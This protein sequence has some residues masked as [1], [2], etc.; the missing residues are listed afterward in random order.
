MNKILQ[1]G[2]ALFSTLI[3]SASGASA[4]ERWIVT[5]SEREAWMA[6]SAL[7][8]VRRV[9]DYEVGVYEAQNGW[10]AVAIGPFTEEKVSIAFYDLMVREV[11]PED[12]RVSGTGCCIQ[13]VERPLGFPDPEDIENTTEPLTLL[14]DLLPQT[15]SWSIL[16]TS[17]EEL[18]EEMS[19]RADEIGT[20]PHSHLFG[21]SI[22]ELHANEHKCM[23]LSKLLQ[24]DLPRGTFEQ[25]YPDP[26]KSIDGE[27]LRLAAHSLGNFHYIV[28]STLP[29]GEDRWKHDWNLGCAD[30][31]DVPSLNYQTPTISAFYDVDESTLRI[32]GDVESGFAQRVIS[33]L[34]MH[35]EVD[36]VALGSGGGYIYEAF[37]AGEAI[38][39]RGLTTTLYNDCMSACTLVF[40]AGTDRLVWS[41]YPRLGFHMAS[42]DGVEL[43]PGDGVYEDIRAYSDWMGISGLRIV[44]LMMK[45]GSSDM[46]FPELEELGRLGV[47][48]WCQR[49][50]C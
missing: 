49:M 40:L 39:S 47:V 31:D 13:T 14:W 11:I 12:S 37:E 8:I 5:N 16:M 2:M 50:A 35:P 44:G 28:Q 26:L 45:A 43:H 27:G 20:P 7:D 36:T 1:T 48:T 15:E 30:S 6:Y 4:E 17:I 38:R 10:L 19:E 9:T 41:P 21:T 3:F 33:A 22:N 24:I 34:Q 29:M 23:I 18:S 42:L 25:E 46:Y 32:L